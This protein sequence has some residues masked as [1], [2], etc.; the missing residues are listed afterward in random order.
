MSITI[1]SEALKKAQQRFDLQ[2]P[3][4][5]GALAMAC[6]P[7]ALL[8]PDTPVPSPF[9]ERIDWPTDEDPQASCIALVN[10]SRGKIESNCPAYIQLTFLHTEHPPSTDNEEAPDTQLNYLQLCILYGLYSIGDAPMVAPLSANRLSQRITISGEAMTIET[11]Q[12]TILS[13]GE[14]AKLLQPFVNPENT[15]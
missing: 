13:F 4:R 10:P 5:K 12:K 8:Y 11:S 7:I 9:V 1:A 15:P 2:N 6:G 3:E 14:A